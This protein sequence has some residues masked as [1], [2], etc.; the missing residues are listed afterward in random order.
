M[1]YDDELIKDD[2]SDLQE[3]NIDTT[4]NYNDSFSNDLAYAFYSV[5]KNE[6][7]DPAIVEYSQNEEEYVLLTVADGLGG[8]GAE[9]V[10][11]DDITV[12]DLQNALQKDFRI[13][14]SNG[15][16]F[17]KVLCREYIPFYE[18]EAAYEQTDSGNSRQT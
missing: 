14:K 1:K 4:N 5:K 12:D 3:K 11:L 10:F 7:A 16:E 15:E 8:S 9:K 6:D 13:V 17:F 18:R 2:I